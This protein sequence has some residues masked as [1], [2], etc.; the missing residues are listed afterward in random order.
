M[1]KSLHFGFIA[2]SLI[3]NASPIADP[4]DGSARATDGGCSETSWES[5]AAIP[6][7]ASGQAA[8]RSDRLTAGVHTKS[9]R[10]VKF[11]VIPKGLPVLHMVPD[12]SKDA[13]VRRRRKPQSW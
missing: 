4:K 12:S 5:E 8:S 13:L 9:I 6:L 7:F 3:K 11:G 10:E 1:S 2:A